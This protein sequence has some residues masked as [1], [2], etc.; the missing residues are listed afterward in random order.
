MSVTHSTIAQMLR[1]AW[2]L[3]RHAAYR[4]CLL[5]AVFGAWSAPFRLRRFD[6]VTLALELVQAFLTECREVAR[7]QRFVRAPFL[8]FLLEEWYLTLRANEALRHWFRRQRQPGFLLAP[9]RLNITVEL[10]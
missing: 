8:R 3:G 10:Q 9:L 6:R 7:T 5:R 2:S 4:I 1:R